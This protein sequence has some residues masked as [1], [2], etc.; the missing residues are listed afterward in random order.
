MTRSLSAGATYFSIVFATAFALGV[1]RVTFIV[2]A[3]GVVW[4]TLAE[5]P[6]TLAVSWVTCAWIRGH[7]RMVSLAQ[8]VSMGVCAFALLMGA[9][10]AG[11][12]LIFGRTLG[13][14]IG[15]Y[16]TAA[17]ALGLVGQIAF[18]SVP[19]AQHLRSKP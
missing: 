4:A 6:L 7:W 2:P 19:V 15:S 3:V 13:D 12:I 5:L 10:A 11:A 14:H 17:G 9:E 1:L 16:G 8:S 18:G